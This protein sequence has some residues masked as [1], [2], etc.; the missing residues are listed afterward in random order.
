M[1]FSLASL[2]LLLSMG[3]A[4]YA[5]DVPPI[6]AP[7]PNHVALGEA[8]DTMTSPS[9]VDRQVLPFAAPAD[10]TLFKEIVPCRLTDSRGNYL[11]TPHTEWV[12][13][14]KKNDMNLGNDCA[15][16]LP[17]TGIVA[18][19]IQIT[20]YNDGTTNGHLM[21]LP[22]Q[23]LGF[24][25]QLYSVLQNTTA[26]LFY[27]NGR[28]EVVQAGTVQIGNNYM[29]NLWNEGGVTNLTIDVLGY[30]V[31]DA[32]VG[33][34]GAQGA[35]GSIGPKGD[36]GA[37]GDQGVQGISGNTGAQGAQGNP[38]AIGATGVAGPKGDKG[39]KGDSGIPGTAGLQG[40]QGAKGDKGDT[41]ASG[42][43]GPA[44]AVGSQGIQG[45]KGDTGAA[46]TVP[47]PQGAQGAKG[48]TGATGAGSPGA[49]GIQGIQG[50]PGANGVCTS[51]CASP[52]AC[53]ST[54]GTHA[55]DTGRTALWPHCT[56][57]LTGVAALEIHYV[58]DGVPAYG[59]RAKNAGSVT[60]SAD[61]NSTYCVL[62]LGDPQN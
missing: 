20:S 1:K 45:V 14:I 26:F 53:Y 55:A 17:D 33:A 58:S 41:G 10:K 2:A 12:Y 15:G 24:V 27:E 5:A 42:V 52:W 19:T 16:K 46:S 35:N 39:D 40:I 21:F 59:A 22:P 60:F 31:N 11:P 51:A 30:H 36:T 57:T 44:G 8:A 25:P 61:T 62:T 32:L 28:K 9:M 48:D 47:G 7:Y 56:V 38:G 13:G 3:T 54:C 4:A 6:V 37:K 34:S 49:Q 18:L 50:P 43:Q 23:H 29:L